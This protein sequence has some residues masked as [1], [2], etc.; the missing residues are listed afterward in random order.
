ML[1]R[2]HDDS[3][4]PPRVRIR[5]ARRE[6]VPTL[7]R[8]AYGCD[9]VVERLNTWGVAELAIHVERDRQSPTATGCLVA[10]DIS[11]LV[12]VATYQVVQLPRWPDP[13]MQISRVIVVP[14]RRRQ[15]IGTRLMQAL[16]RQA[17]LIG[18]GPMM[19]R[20]AATNVIG[21]RFSEGLGAH[22]S[23][24]RGDFFLSGNAVRWLALALE[25]EAA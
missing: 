12:G 19:W 22:A 11:S 9:D 10:A 2:P 1:T 5:A 13:A 8:L 23:D 6:D 25:E 7:L 18:C 14:S 16:A 3:I 4:A 24:G 20:V 15:H 17:D 21:I